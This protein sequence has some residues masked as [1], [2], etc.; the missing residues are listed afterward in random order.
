MVGGEGI[1]KGVAFGLEH[2]AFLVVFAECLVEGRSAGVGGNEK[3]TERRSFGFIQVLF[4][5]EV[6]LRGKD[7]CEHTYPHGDSSSDEI[8]FWDTIWD[9]N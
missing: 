7:T 1:G 3:D 6:K 4:V 9:I 5:L 8:D 2:E